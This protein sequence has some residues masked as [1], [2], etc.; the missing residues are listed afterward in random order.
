MN[1]G[2]FQQPDELIRQWVCLGVDGLLQDHAP[3]PVLKPLGDR[4]PQINRCNNANLYNCMQP[5]PYW[6][7]T[8]PFYEL[9]R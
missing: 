3:V 7:I 4:N 5:A 1:N 6:V 8:N 2:R 9:Q